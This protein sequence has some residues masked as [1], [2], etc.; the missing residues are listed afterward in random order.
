M[1]ART[2]SGSRARFKINGEHV[3]F[4]GGVSGEESVDHEPVDVLNLIEV[5]EFVPVGYRANLSA[6]MFRFVGQSVKVLG[7]FP[8]E[9]NILTT[10]EMEASVEDTLEE[11]RT[12]YLFQGVRAATRGFDLNARSLATEN[13]SFVAIRALDESEV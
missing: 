7:I 12:A 8:L 9:S 11:G 10:G 2:L 5:F 4:A 3:A 1:A 13:L 6:N